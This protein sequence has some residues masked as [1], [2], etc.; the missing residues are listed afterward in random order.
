M[1]QDL[2]KEIKQKWLQTSVRRMSYQKMRLY[3]HGLYYGYK[4]IFGHN[5]HYSFYRVRQGNVWI[6]IEKRDTRKQMRYLEEKFSEAKYIIKNLKQLGKKMIKDFQECEADIRKIPQGWRK[7]G[8]GVLLGALKKYYEID[9]RV[10]GFYWILFN[11]IENILVR[12]AKDHMIRSGVKKNEIEQALIVLSRPVRITPLDM[13]QISIFKMALRRGKEK[14]SVLLRHWKEFAHMPMYD[15][16][17]N[18]YSIEHFEKELKKITNRFSRAAIKKKINI[19]IKKYAAR[20]AQK[21]EIIKK[22]AAFPEVA[23]IL[24]FYGIYA[25][26]KDRKLCVRDR[27]SFYVKNLFE[28]VAKRLGI[29]LQEVLFLKD[30]EIA[31]GLKNGKILPKAE[32]AARVENSAFL[33]KDRKVVIFTKKDDLEIIDDILSKKEDLKDLMGLAVSPGKVKAQVSLIISNADFKKFKK[34]RVLVTSATRPDFVPLMKKAAAIITDEGGLLSHAA[35]VS[36]E[37]GIPCIVGTKIATRV[38]K[39][40]DLVEVDADRGLV[41]ILERN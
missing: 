18:E 10:S 7:A 21:D 20:Q 13:E 15:I 36:R 24:E 37:L 14:Q 32:I 12:S 6:Y 27:I 5:Q 19:I 22:Y 25:I 38:L 4:N 28:E 23:A 31:S 33:L 8:N 40:G 35:I 11:D 34:G 17:Y 2:F 9:N 16:G 39:D 29:S 1:N 41:K 30:T 3:Q 26:Y